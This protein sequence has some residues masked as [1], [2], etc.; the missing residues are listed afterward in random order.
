V[1]KNHSKLRVVLA[2]D[3]GAKAGKRS[4]QP[5]TSTKNYSR[6]WE[7]GMNVESVGI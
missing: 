4:C 5:T 7:S 1:S 3:S 2:A 6:A